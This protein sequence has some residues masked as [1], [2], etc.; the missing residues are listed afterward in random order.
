MT[1][2]KKIFGDWRA[3][4]SLDL[5][6]LAILRIIV[7]LFFIFDLHNRSIFLIQDYTDVGSFPRFMLSDDWSSWSFHRLSGGHVFQI[8]LFLLSTLFALFLLLGKWTFLS[9]FISFVLL[10]SLQHRNPAIRFAFDSYLSGILFWG[11]WTPWGK[12]LSIDSMKNKY[13]KISKFGLNIGTLGLYIQVASVYFFTVLFKNSEIW[14]NANTAV[15][16][17]LSNDQFRRP[18]AVYLLQYKSLL[19][20]LS[21]LTFK[22]WILIP[23]VLIIPFKSNWPR[24]I[25]LISAMAIHIGIAVLIRMDYYPQL[26]CL[27]LLPFLHWKGDEVQLVRG[28]LNLKSF[29][30]IFLMLIMALV[31]IWNFFTLAPSPTIIYKTLKNGVTLIGLNHHWGMFAPEP[32]RPDGRPIAEALLTSGQTVDLLRKDRIFD[33]AKK[34]DIYLQIASQRRRKNFNKLWK[35]EALRA[36]YSKWLCWRENQYYNSPDKVVS[37]KWH[38]LD[39]FGQMENPEPVRRDFETHQCSTELAP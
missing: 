6:S 5:T 14:Q 22:I 2:H 20:L 15:E 24:N 31:F 1:F 36:S 29:K 25:V 21:W 3:H 30:N 38:Y 28:K 37:I 23:V 39:E 27:S 4:F 10:I 32:F 19:S 13:S 8:I 11:M 16:I 12:Q 33:F 18:W 26:A 7:A 35:S 9:S 34:D 17:I